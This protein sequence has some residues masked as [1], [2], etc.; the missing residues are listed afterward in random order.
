M[1]TMSGCPACCMAASSARPMPASMP[2][3]SSAPAWSRSMSLGARFPGFVA[4]V[5]IGDFVGVVAEREENAIKAAA[6]LNVTWKPVP[7]LPGLDNIEQ[8]LRANPSTP[9]R[10][11]TRATSTPRSRPPQGRCS[12]PMSGRI[13]CMAR[14]VRPARLPIFRTAHPRLVRHAEP[15]SA[16]RRPCAVDRPARAEST[17]SGWKPPAATA[18][19]AQTMFPPMRCCCRARWPPRSRAIDPRAGARLGAEGHC[20]IDGRQWRVECRWQRRGLR[21]CHALSLQRRA[22]IGA[23][24]DRRG[25]RRSRPCSRWATAPRSRLTTTTIFAWSRTT[26]RRSCVRHGFAVSR[27]CPIRLRMNPISTSSHPKPASI[28]SSTGCAT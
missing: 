18:A 23:V 16:A 4:V 22:D 9:R 7:T 12:A 8:A 25:S 20:A 10:C 1:S 24:A 21:F 27:R 2:G 13:R 19:I 3:P 14:S 28:P 17:S 6:R 5:R 11:S 26:C 15:P